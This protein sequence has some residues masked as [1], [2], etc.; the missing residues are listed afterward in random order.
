[1]KNK[2]GINFN[3]HSLRHTHATI[4][5]K[6]GQPIK[7]VQK[8]LGH[9]RSATTEDCYVHLTQKM[10]RDAADIFDSTAKDL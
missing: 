2:L 10:T 9:S 1:M 8:K 5:I 6:S 3:Y 7:T 4:L